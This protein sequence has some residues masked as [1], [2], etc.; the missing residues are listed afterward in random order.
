[1]MQ[2]ASE[3]LGVSFAKRYFFKKNRILLLISTKIYQSIFEFD[4]ERL[5]PNATPIAMDL[6]DEDMITLNEMK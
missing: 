5:D 3:T 1:M 2:K 4:G 6:E